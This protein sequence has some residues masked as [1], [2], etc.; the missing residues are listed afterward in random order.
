MRCVGDD[1]GGGWCVLTSCVW[2]CS[3]L[4][5]GVTRTA[6]SSALTAPCPHAQLVPR[7]AALSFP[8][9]GAEANPLPMHTAWRRTS[10]SMGLVSLTGS[11]RVT[12][13][14]VQSSCPPLVSHAIWSDLRVQLRLTA[15]GFHCHYYAH[16]GCAARLSILQSRESSFSCRLSVEHET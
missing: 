8:S 14:W 16:L 12:I 1:S 11:P 3:F 7:A 4:V 15:L 10:S 2:L 6:A 13:S 5:S 9:V